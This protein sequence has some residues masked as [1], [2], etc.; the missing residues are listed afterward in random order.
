MRESVLNRRLLTRDDRRKW[1][2]RHDMSALLRGNTAARMAG[3]QI[4]RNLGAV[5]ADEIRIKEGMVPIG[6]E[7]G[8]DKY[9]VQAQYTPL[10][11]AGKPVEPAPKTRDRRAARARRGRKS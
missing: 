3:Y 9:L 8:G 6:P 7:K 10:D 2:I 11:Q 1:V 5:N 4:L